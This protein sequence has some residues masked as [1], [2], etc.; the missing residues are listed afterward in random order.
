MRFA[1]ISILL[2]PCTPNI[3]AINS[4]KLKGLI[5]S[6]ILEIEDIPEN[7]ELTEKQRLQA[8]LEKF[9]KS[10][11][12]RENIQNSINQLCYPLYFIDYETYSSAIPAIDNISPHQH[13]PFQV[14]I[15]IL[16]SDGRLTHFEYLSKTIKNAIL[17]LIEFMKKTISSAGSVI[18]W[19]AS[20][21]NSKNK[22][23]AEIY[24]EHSEFLFDLNKRTFDLEKVFKKDYLI[25]EFRGRTSIKVVLPALIPKISYKNLDIQDGGM[26]MEQW[27]I[28]VF[29]DIT[30]IKRQKIADNLLEYC[31]MDTLAMVEIFKLIQ[32]F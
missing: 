19:H 25:P 10:R 12:N 31:K 7:F 21:E 23:M 4:K 29:G 17:G 30:E 9:Q 32:R 6:G 15:H 27:R 11:I 1:F 3:S 28:M 13:I 20:F 16:D 5:D 22:E 2:Y 24:S 8:D 14:S 26:A 18:F